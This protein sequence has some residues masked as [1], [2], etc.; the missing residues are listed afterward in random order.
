MTAGN[1][2]PR[3]VAREKLSRR[4][5]KHES[6]DHD[7]HPQKYLLACDDFDEFGV[8]FQT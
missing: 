2:C 8:K 3:Q 4:Q 7:D 5:K 6:E 1:E